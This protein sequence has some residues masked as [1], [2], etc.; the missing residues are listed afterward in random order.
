MVV[1][2]QKETAKRGCA[3]EI[4]VFGRIEQ[5]AERLGVAIEEP[6]RIVDERSC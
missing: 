5:A 3:I 4:G 1:F 6:R 2:V